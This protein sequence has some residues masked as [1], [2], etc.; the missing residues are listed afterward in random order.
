M[1]A[2]HAKCRQCGLSFA[3]TRAPCSTCE[4]IVGATCPH[5]D[6][7]VEHVPKPIAPED[8]DFVE[9][10][11]PAPHGRKND[12]GKRRWSLLPWGA[13]GRVV[14]VLT[15]GAVKY[16]DDNWRHV[17]DARERYFSAAMRHLTAWESDEDND[18]E[19]GLPHL[20]HVACCVLFILALEPRES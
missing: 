18:P 14:D 16:S 12:A 3:S 8:A 9:R 4:A 17:P 19:T 11:E 1:I 7:V 6:T 5:C 13:V 10:L 2:H 15:L 20:A